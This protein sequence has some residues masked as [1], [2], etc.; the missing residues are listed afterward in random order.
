MGLSLYRKKRNFSATPEPKGKTPVKKTKKKK[1]FIIQKHAASHL[2]YDFR[3]ELNGVLLSWAVPKGPCLD[4]SVKRLAMH[5]ED[6]PL[7]YGTFEGIIPK[8]QYGGG[9]VM[10]WDKGEWE[11]EE[12]DPVVAYH[13]GS[14][15]FV[16]NAKKLNGKWKLIRMHGDD[17]TWLLFKVKDKYAKPLKD[18]DIT[19]KKPNSVLTNQSLDEIAENY[20]RVWGKQGEEKAPKKKSL[21]NN[22]T[23]KIQFKNL[24]SQFNLKKSAFPRNIFPELATLVDKPPMQDNWLHEIKLDGYRLIA[25]KKN[26]QTT[27]FTRNQNDWTHY[28]ETIAEKINR[29]PV[30][31]VILD[32]EVVVL[33]KNQHSNFQL[34]QNAIKDTK[35]D[36]F[37]YYVF[38]LLYL[39]HISLMSLPLIKRKE[40]LK[41]IISDK[42]T[43]LR[44][45]DHV[46]G[47][48]DKVFK[49]ACELTLEGI[50]SKDAHSAYLQKRT[51][52]WLKTK[53]IK[54]QEFIIGGFTPPR[55][56]RQC[57]GSL[58]IGTYNKQHELIYNGRVGTGFTQTSL[59]SIYR[60]LLKHKSQQ[61]PFK[62]PPPASGKATW[63]KPVLIAEVEFTEWT[64]DNALRHPSFK[65]LRKDKPAKLIHK[66]SALPIAKIE[67][68]KKRKK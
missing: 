21:K 67:K 54:R 58:L 49:K 24:I 51:T 41:Q 47:S 28:F 30:E 26:K 39:N 15:S 64:T 42:T 12:A 13:K 27:L 25:F 10:L 3:I 59:Q 43:I 61:M 6:H 63:V 56:S 35:K 7:E 1:L 18:F 8:N 53:C 5:V 52:D 2:H 40:M 19:L 45:N 16:L 36:P 20:T 17:K 32:G 57:L 50:V 48:G 23:K 66:E 37:I 31:N 9:T 14:L 44:F 55:G 34:L 29:L 60:E 46:F 11:C 38:D 62:N 4:P 33:D 65:G 22:A 68:S